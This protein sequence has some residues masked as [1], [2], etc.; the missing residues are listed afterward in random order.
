[1]WSGAARALSGHLRI[2]KPDLPGHGEN[3]AAAPSSLDSHADFLEALLEDLPAPVGLA[4][5]SMG[6]YVL[7]ALMRRRPEKVG[8]I[9][10]VDSR[11]A[12]D[13][14]AGK[15]F[16]DT[17]IGMIRSGGAAAILEPTIS[18]LL[19]PASLSNRDLV[20][21]VRRI[22][23]RQKP[24]TVEADLAA[25]RDRADA[26]DLLSTISV[27]ALVVVGDQ[28]V[29]SKPAESRAM[30][31]AIPGARFSTIPMAGHLTPMERPK[32]VAAALSQFFGETLGAPPEG[33]QPNVVKTEG[34]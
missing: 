29:I 5:F 19:A 27:P 6:G 23:L 4:G 34:S 21:R 8:A 24:E 26:R 15:A 32:A 9:A 25:M 33:S 7:F 1:M 28:D 12:A 18:H 11:A 16:R 14:E 30:A 3:P 13:D 2:L 22:I 10:L 17:T 20:E 31:D